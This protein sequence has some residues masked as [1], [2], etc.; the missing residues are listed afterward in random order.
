MWRLQRFYLTQALSPK[1]PGELNRFA[2]F[3][4]VSGLAGFGTA[5][6][7]TGI[8]LHVL[9]P[10]TSATLS[11]ICSVA[12]QIQTLPS[13][14]REIKPSRVLPFIIP[15][16]LGVPLGLWV[17]RYADPASFKLGAGLLL[18][19]FPVFMLL[20]RNQPAVT[21]G[22][23]RA[24][25]AIGFLGG[26]LGGL[27]GLSGAP[28]TIWASLRG[29]SK[30]QKRGVFQSYN[31]AILATALAGHVMAG[32]LTPTLGL[33]VLLALPGTFLGAWLG[34]ATYRRL[35]DRNFSDLVMILLLISGLI[36]LASLL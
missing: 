17:L 34:V 33:L 35:N 28:P 18:S 10:A 13:V 16:L 1:N 22:G 29:W 36:L 2:V 4:F 24:D 20:W 21:W 14:W 27:A 30:D 25:A 23:R 11:L 31:L 8:W 19:T 5:L 6:T 15:G 12:A 26:I 7:T 3:G 32:R 9:D